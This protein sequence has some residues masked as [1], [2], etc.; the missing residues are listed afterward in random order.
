MGQKGRPCRGFHPF[1]ELTRHVVP[2]RSK[3]RTRTA[4]RHDPGDVDQGSYGRRGARCAGGTTA[5]DAGT[6]ALCSTTR[7][8]RAEPAKMLK[9]RGDRAGMPRWEGPKALVQRSGK[10]VGLKSYQVCGLTRR[11]HFEQQA[12]SFLCAS[13]LT[14]HAVFS[15]TSGHHVTRYQMIGQWQ[16]GR[17]ES[18]TS[19]AGPID[20]ASGEP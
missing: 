3:S 1:A 15:S 11:G 20:I 13:R 17:A 4:C 19:E 12:E 18:R 9:N 16:P 2:R 7:L 14:G 5:T 10:D 6:C 8:S